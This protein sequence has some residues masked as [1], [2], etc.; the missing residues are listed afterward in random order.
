MGENS[1]RKT[2]LKC[3]VWFPV[4]ITS[5]SLMT[6]DE[7]KEFNF[8]FHQTRESGESF[9]CFVTNYKQVSIVFHFSGK[10]MKMILE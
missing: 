7:A 5:T 10:E 4:D 8:W 3:H 1:R 9:R 2:T 6:R